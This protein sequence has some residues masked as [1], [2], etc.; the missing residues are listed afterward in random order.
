MATAVL[1]LALIGCKYLRSNGVVTMAIVT[2]G[3]L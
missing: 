1:M 3:N 2:R